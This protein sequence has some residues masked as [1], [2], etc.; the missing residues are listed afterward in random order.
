M[1]APRQQGS[2]SGT[3]TTKGKASSPEGPPTVRT[4]EGTRGQTRHS[5]PSL[6]HWEPS[7]C[8][9]LTTSFYHTQIKMQHGLKK[10]SKINCRFTAYRQG[11]RPLAKASGEPQKKCVPHLNTG[12][13]YPHATQHRSV[14]QHSPSQVLKEFPF[15]LPMFLPGKV[16][17]DSSKNVS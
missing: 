15:L 16:L 10:R 13:G 3:Y 4:V 2:Q 5:F 14:L 17:G 12:A 9:A 6:K 7:Q 8:S 11:A 1:Y